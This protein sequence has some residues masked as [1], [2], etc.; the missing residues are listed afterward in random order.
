MYVCSY[1]ILGFSSSICIRGVDDE[2]GHKVLRI[3]KKC[4]TLYAMIYKML[5]KQQRKTRLN[6]KFRFLLH[7]GKRYLLFKNIFY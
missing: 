7:E 5:Y 6:I 4:N 3:Y 1:K 2:Q